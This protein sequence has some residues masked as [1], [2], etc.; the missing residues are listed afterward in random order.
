[1]YS[2]KK[3]RFLVL[4]FALFLLSNF[5]FGQANEIKIRFIGN[6]GLYMTDGTTNFYIDFPYKSGAHNYMEYDKSEIDS[7]KDN[8][9]FIFTH[10]HADHYSNKILKKMSGQKFDP[11][12][13]G[14][15]EKLGETIPDF[16]IKAFKTDHTVFGISFKH[17][18]YLVTWHGK[19]IFFSGDTANSETI[20]SQTNLDW[21]FVPIWL[22]MDAKEKNV[23]LK[24]LSKK[25]AIYHIG[26]KDRITLDEKDSQLKLLDRQG[27]VIR[28]SFEQ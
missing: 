21:A 26:P 28:I 3:M 13:I 7:I 10:R 25:Y 15:L 20:A 8:A 18:S 17:Y 1:M 23:D 2:T 4:N 12:N 11:W 24:N 5:A 14:E 22:L 27:E 16:T 19:K 9:V 6:C